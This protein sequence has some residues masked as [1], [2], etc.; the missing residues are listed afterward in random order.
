MRL[1]IALVLASAFACGKKSPSATSQCADV[2]Q[3]GVD[4]MVARA[5]ERAASA[6]LP[7]DI[8][9][10]IEERTKQ[11]DAL[12]P[13]LRAVITNRCVDDKWPAEVIECYGKVTSMEESRACRAK[14][15]PEQQAKVQKEELDLYAGAMGPPGFGS[16][17]VPTSPE[18]TKLE[19]ELRDENAKLAAAAKKL[20]GATTDA[21]RAATKAEMQS[22]QQQMQATNDELA[23]AR[24][25]AASTPQPPGPGSAA[26]SGSN[27]P[28]GS[29]SEPTGSVG[30]AK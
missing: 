16:A 14:L 23:K 6:Q 13:R 27:R 9:A 29:S 15:S 3:K 30:S 28:V 25:N 19:A 2:A 24:A 12:A 26:A 4:A 11:L 22:L 8:R 7:A 17:H 21:D 18:I 20:E 10:K 1:V 5:H